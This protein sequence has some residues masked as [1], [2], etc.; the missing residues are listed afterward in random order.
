MPKTG[1]YLGRHP[2]FH[3]GELEVL[4]SAQATAGYYLR[5]NGDPRYYAPFSDGGIPPDPPSS[6]HRTSRAP[7]AT[8]GAWTPS[9]ASRRLPAGLRRRAG[10]ALRQ[11]ART[12]WSAS[13]DGYEN[14]ARAVRSAGID[15][16]TTPGSAT[17]AGPLSTMTPAVS[18]HGDVVDRE[19]GAEPLQIDSVEDNQSGTLRR[20]R[21]GA[22]AGGT[23]AA[24][25]A[26]T[27]TWAPRMAEHRRAG[28]RLA[29]ASVLG[30]FLTFVAACPWA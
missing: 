4:Y 26:W 28:A 27:S 11:R 16:A 30:E 3:L 29:A 5:R 7:S 19:N 13:T 14:A 23:R 18:V 15:A 6:R 24:R 9:T 12:A 22:R 17:R 2:V 8:S 1:W 25:S 21:A 10:R 20:R